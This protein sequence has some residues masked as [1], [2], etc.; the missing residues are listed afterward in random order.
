MTHLDDVPTDDEHR[1]MAREMYERRLAGEKKSRIEIS[2]HA[3]CAAP[4]ELPVI[5]GIGARAQKGEFLRVDGM[6]I[7]VCGGD[8][9][10]AP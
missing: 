3:R 5:V 9:C 1:R 8:P 10:L 2:R 4:G 6:L 7:E